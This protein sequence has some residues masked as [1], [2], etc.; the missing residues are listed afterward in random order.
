MT[1]V[2]I[3][4]GSNVG[5]RIEHLRYALSHLQNKK[6]LKILRTSALYQTAPLGYEDQEWFVNAVVE[7]ETSLAPLQLLE[8]LQSIETKMGRDTPFRWGP[9][10]IDLDLL[11]FGKRIVDEPDLT[12]PHPL[13]D[14][15]R[16]VMEPLAELAPEGMHP[17]RHKTFQEILEELGAAQEIKKMEEKL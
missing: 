4:L 13:A 5:D 3:G 1:T 15:R 10:N 6:G 8:L 12:V 9:R 16:F 2:Y 11:I 14:Q 7:G 17:T